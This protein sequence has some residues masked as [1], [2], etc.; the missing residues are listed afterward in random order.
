VLVGTSADGRI[1]GFCD[2]GPNRGEPK[3]FQGE[4]YAIYLLAEA[5]G[6]GLGRALFQ[7]AVAWLMRNGWSSFLVWV[8]TGNTRARRFYEALGGTAAG[9][10]PTAIAGTSYTEVAYGWREG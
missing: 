10:K 7:Q 2:A 4:V 3:D 9:E 6:Q 5:Q 8:L 1:V